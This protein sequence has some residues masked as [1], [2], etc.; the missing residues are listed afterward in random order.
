MIDYDYRRPMYF[1][2]LGLVYAYFVSKDTKYIRAHSATFSDIANREHGEFLHEWHNLSQPPKGAI[3]YT[4]Q[5]PLLAELL[6]TMINN[7]VPDLPYRFELVD[8]AGMEDSIQTLTDDDIDALHEEHDKE[9]YKN[10][11]PTQRTAHDP[12]GRRKE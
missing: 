6:H 10:W 8:I 2:H 9:Q 11:E 1:V 7:K 3:N 5:A 4:F 12:Y